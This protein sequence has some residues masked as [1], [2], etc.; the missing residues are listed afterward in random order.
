MAIH[1]ALERLTGNQTTQPLASALT[2][3]VVKSVLYELVYGVVPTNA[4]NLSTARRPTGQFEEPSC[5]FDKDRDKDHVQEA[6]QSMFPSI[7]KT[8]LILTRWLREYR[9]FS[10]SSAFMI[11]RTLA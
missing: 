11:R 2:S 1:E 3:P 9:I 7:M 10:S 5:V 4:N 8:S 6:P